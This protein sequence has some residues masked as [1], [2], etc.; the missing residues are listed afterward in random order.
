[1]G[2]MATQN[3]SLNAFGTSPKGRNRRPPYVVPP[4][5][6]INRPFS[7]SIPIK[8]PHSKRP[9]RL[10]PRPE[11]PHQQNQ[12]PGPNRVRPKLHPPL[13]RLLL[14][15]RRDGRDHRRRIGALH[16]PPARELGNLPQHVELRRLPPLLPARPLHGNRRLQSRTR[17]GATQPHMM[18]PRL[19]RREDAREKPPRIFARRRQTHA[20]DLAGG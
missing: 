6:G 10:P 3:R 5:G 2:A 19:P 15:Q 1:M 8:A 7:A 9:R 11:N 4:L 12:K 14:R 17:I 13:L 18:L 16:Q 20:R